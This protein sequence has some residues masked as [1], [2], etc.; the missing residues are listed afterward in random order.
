MPAR[1]VVSGVGGVSQGT[2]SFSI[3]FE[4]GTDIWFVTAGGPPRVLF[5]KYE[6]K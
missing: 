6:F 5:S 3:Q 2:E 1:K 4:D